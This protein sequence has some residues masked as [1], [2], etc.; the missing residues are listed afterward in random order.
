MITI[1]VSNIIYLILGLRGE[2][3]NLLL[4]DILVSIFLVINDEVD[5]SKKLNNPEVK[6]NAG[7]FAQLQD[8]IL[9]VELEDGTKVP[10]AVKLND[11]KF[12]KD[13]VSYYRDLY[14]C[15]IANTPNVERCHEF[16]D[17]L[18]NWK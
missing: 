15:F 18:N 7:E 12:Y 8:K 14:I 16:W 6:M 4:L 1:F 13:C 2:S 17:Y 5:F 3:F 9:Y 11:T 10:C